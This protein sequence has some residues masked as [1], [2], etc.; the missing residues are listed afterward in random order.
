MPQIPVAERDDWRM[1][2]FTVSKA[3]ERSRRIRTD[4]REAACAARSDSLTES[5]TVSVE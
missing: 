4:D 1:E 3:A 5:S 2:W